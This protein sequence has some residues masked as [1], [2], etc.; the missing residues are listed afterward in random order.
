M[1]GETVKKTTIC[2][3]TNNCIAIGTVRSVQSPERG[4]YLRGPFT[5]TGK[6]VFVLKIQ[7]L[8]VVLLCRCVSSSLL[9]ECNISFIFWII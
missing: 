8:F 6:E 3:S 1:H 4:L 7:S 5:G 9:L 2:L